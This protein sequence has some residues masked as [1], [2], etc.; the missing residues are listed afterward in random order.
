[1]IELGNLT[2]VTLIATVIAALFGVTDLIAVELECQ[3]A[4]DGTRWITGEIRGIV[5]CRVLPHQVAPSM[6][7]AS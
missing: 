5:I 6:S 1:M 4:A 2:S 7:A 3:P